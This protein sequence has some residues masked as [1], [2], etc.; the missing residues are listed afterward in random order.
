MITAIVILA[1]LKGG[2]DSHL[3]GQRNYSPGPMNYDSQVA[4]NNGAA[5]A[6]APAT[7]EISLPAEAKVTIDDTITESISASRTFVSPPLEPGM[8]YNYTIKVEMM[9]GGQL[10]TAS[11]QIIVRA[12]EVAK[13][14]V[15]IPE[16]MAQR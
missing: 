5:P 2:G 11:K 9:R 4:D 13:V 14:T 15:K 8:D 10:M 3:F 16:D 1:M 12:G 6:Q 7:I